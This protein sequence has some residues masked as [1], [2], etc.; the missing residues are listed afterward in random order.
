VDLDGDV[1]D[2][3]DRQ[4]AFAWLRKRL[5]LLRRRATWRKLGRLSEE[6][7]CGREFLDM[8][9]QRCPE[10]ATR[11]PAMGAEIARC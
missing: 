10:I 7:R 5:Q 9:V 4:F 3:V 1:V 11:I 6:T 8:L 2:I